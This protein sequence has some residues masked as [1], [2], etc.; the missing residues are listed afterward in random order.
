MIRRVTLAAALVT[1]GAVLMATPASAGG[2]GVPDVKVAKAK[3]GPYKGNN[4]YNNTGEGQTVKK[5]A[6]PGAVKQFFIKME[7]DGSGA[8]ELQFDCPFDT[9]S[10]VKLRF[11]HA[12]TE[13]T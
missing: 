3:S 13:I 9:A 8:E 1:A 2:A 12:A 6:K 11:F 10:D 7:N 4:S 5:R